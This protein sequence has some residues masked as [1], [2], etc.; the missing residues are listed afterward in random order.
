MLFI[1]CLSNNIVFSSLDIS[2]IVLKRLDES[3]GSIKSPWRYDL[4][5]INGV[6]DRCTCF[7]GFLCR[8]I[9]QARCTMTKFDLWS[10]K[11]CNKPKGSGMN[12]IFLICMRSKYN[13]ELAIK[14]LEYKA[15]VIKYKKL[16]VMQPR[17]KTNPNLLLVNKPSR[18]SPYE[19]LQLWLIN[20]VWGGGL[21]REGGGAYK[22]SSPEKGG[23]YWAGRGFIWDGGLNRGFTVHD[24]LA[25]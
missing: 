17:I 15:E 16:E 20:T 18:I 7:V 19:V 4:C 11:P 1:F 14:K 12:L 10:P 23:A 8:I 5:T 13:K 22:L 25:S 6:Q 21:K 2:T 9:M 24:I 3:K